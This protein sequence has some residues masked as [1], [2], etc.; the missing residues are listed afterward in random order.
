MASIP[1][2]HD[3][4]IRL[5]TTSTLPHLQGQVQRKEIHR[6]PGKTEERSLFNDLVMQETGLWIHSHRQD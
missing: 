4:I 1:H 6:D 2:I 5:T 3:R